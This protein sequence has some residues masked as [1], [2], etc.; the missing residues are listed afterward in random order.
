MSPVNEVDQQLATCDETLCQLK[1]NLHAANNRM[2]QVVNSKRREL[3]FQEGDWVF[4]KLHPYRQ[5]TVFK[6]AF[7]KLVSHFFVPI[8]LPKR[9]VKWRI[10]FSCLKDLVFIPFSTFHC[11]KENWETLIL[12]PLSCHRLMMME[13]FSYNLK[14][15]WTYDGLKKGQ[16]LLRKVLSNGNSFHLKMPLGKTLKSTGEVSQLEP[17]GQSSSE[18][19]RY[20]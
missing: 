8:R 5:R 2:Q 12:L 4:L 16:S 17:W 1:A 3:E 14:P 15:S 9:L 19:G 13:K 11:L 18:W 7:Q 10:S 20:W 6:R